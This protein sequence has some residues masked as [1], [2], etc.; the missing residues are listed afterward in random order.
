MEFKN[1]DRLVKL[2]SLFL[3]SSH[4]QRKVQGVGAINTHNKPS[5]CFHM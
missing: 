3:N 2:D 4:Q 1:Q 5:N